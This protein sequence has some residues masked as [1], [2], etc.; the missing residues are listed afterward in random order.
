M[1]PML[2]RIMPSQNRATPALFGFV[3]RSGAGKNTIITD[4]IEC[5]RLD[6]FTVSTIK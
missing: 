1:S 3:G 2:R 4:E 6:R 5:L